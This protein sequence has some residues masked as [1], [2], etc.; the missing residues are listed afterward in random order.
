LISENIRSTKTTAHAIST[1]AN[2]SAKATANAF[3]HAFTSK[4]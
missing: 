1:A 2:A 3:L 4:A